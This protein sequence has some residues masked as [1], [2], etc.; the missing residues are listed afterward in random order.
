[1]R[2]ASSAHTP[3]ARRIA[4]VLLVVLGSVQFFSCFNDK[5][6][7]VGPTWDVDLT[8]PLANRQFSVSDLIGK[9]PSVLKVG[10]GNILV[11]ST[12]QSGDPDSVRN[13]I[14]LNPSP[15]TR[16]VKFGVFD[17]TP[18]VCPAFL[19]DPALPPGSASSIP[20]AIL[21]FPVIE[22]TMRTF[23][24]A[25][26]QS[27]T[28]SLTL[29][30]NLSTQ[31][32]VL[33][34]IALSD[35][36]GTIATF[37]FSGAGSVLAAGGGKQTAT[38]PLADGQSID[39]VLTLTGLRLHVVGSGVPAVIPP[40]PFVAA[41]SMLDLRAHDAQL[42]TIPP[43]RLN[44][45]DT[46]YA[47]MDD[48][49]K[50]LEAQ[51]R[52]GTMRFDLV[53]RIPLDMEFVYALADLQRNAG[54]FYVPFRDS[55]PLAAGSS[56]TRMDNVAGLRIRSHLGALIDSLLIVSSVEL[57][58]TSYNVTLHDTDK[59]QITYSVTSPIV[60]DTAAAVLKPT[61]INI[62]STIPLRT[63]DVQKKFSGQLNIPSATLSLNAQSTIG[64]PMD[65]AV[66][67]SAVN[68]STGVP[69]LLTPQTPT[70]RI[71]SSTTGSILF[72][73]SSVGRFL[74]SFSG[75]LPDSVQVSGYAIVNPP[76]QYVPTLAG[77]G[78]VS[79]RSFVAGTVNLD[80]PFYCGISNGSYRDTTENTVRPDDVKQVNV[81]TMYVEVQNG[82]PAQVT[83]NLYLLDSTGTRVVL[84]VPQSGVP[85]GVSAAPVDAA[86]NVS[87]VRLSTSS[88]SL[89]EN[90]VRMLGTGKYVA[91]TA[92]IATTGS[93]Q[94]VRFRT[95]DAVNIR[96][97][98][99]LSF[100]VNK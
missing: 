78:S 10:A 84:R 30:N 28:V 52:T 48:S 86:G 76:D 17:M 59:V 6:K 100:Q 58:D 47:A 4:I 11:Y 97:W 42:A 22:D 95:T 96:V 51:C 16:Y 64:F 40:T 27:G 65:V 98:S 66:T 62:S 60:A 31:V 19:S 83:I 21:T 75:K 41:L 54:G 35:L 5:L 8:L 63:G 57:L 72:D 74:S 85:I 61:R 45:N 79:C 24:T 32:E 88:V 23:V 26:L 49:T 25:R 15:S 14:T 18:E 1:M 68:P 53:N 7:P 91:Y 12:S 39:R 13:Q 94:P 99:R 37:S 44:N 70:T 82:L 77:V 29:V 46:T 33:D 36:N 56:G 67:L 89:N 87:A 2:P 50:L 43:Q 90:E 34:P 93:G 81:G 71:Q 69:A 20:D 80:V 9:D 55:L 3:E 38:A 92:A 73:P